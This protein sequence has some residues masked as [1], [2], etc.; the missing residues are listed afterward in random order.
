[1]STCR[2][3]QVQITSHL[4]AALIF[5]CLP[6]RGKWASINVERCAC[7][8]QNMAISYIFVIREI[9]ENIWKRY[10][11]QNPT[12][13][14]PSDILGIYAQFLSYHQKYQRSR[15]HKP[16][17]VHG[18]KGLSIGVEKAVAVNPYAAVG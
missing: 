18:R 2:D 10:V 13:N 17:D 8:T 11:N 5:K 4:P 3:G 14:S 6:A 7:F 9:S 12:H 16:G 15:R 1:M